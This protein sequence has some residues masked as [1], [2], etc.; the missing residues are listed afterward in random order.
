V[1]QGLACPYIEH[2]DY[3]Y[4]SSIPDHNYRLIDVGELF[5]VVNSTSVLEDDIFMIKL[6]LGSEYIYVPLVW[7]HSFPLLPNVH[8]WATLSMTT[9][10]FITNKKS[11][12]L[13]IPKVGCDA[14]SPTSLIMFLVSNFA[15]I[16][17]R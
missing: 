5:I 7:G 4:C 14:Q 1:A 6:S 16:Q 13:G 10:Q 12:A 8:L 17:Y 15:Y 9:E 2:F 11:A 3:F